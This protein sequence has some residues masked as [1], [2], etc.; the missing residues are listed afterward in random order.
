MTLD[1]SFTYMC[2]CSPSSTN[3]YRLHCRKGYGSNMRRSGPP[4]MG[5]VRLYRVAGNTVG[6]HMAG[7]ASAAH[8]RLGAIGNG[9]GHCSHMSE[10]CERACW[11]SAIKPFYTQKQLLLSVHLSHHNSVCPPVCLSHGWISQNRC[12]LGLP[13]LFH[14]LPGRLYFPEPLSFTINS[15]GGHPERG[16]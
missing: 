2:L 9:D 15:K 14:R 4:A 8:C 11:L 7:E 12:K 10:S 13:N 5:R 3:W 16:C 1:K 6:S